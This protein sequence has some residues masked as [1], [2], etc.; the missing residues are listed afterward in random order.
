M[1]SY[2]LEDDLTLVNFEGTLTET[3]L[4]RCELVLEG[5]VGHLLSYFGSQ[6]LNL[7]R[8]FVTHGLLNAELVEELVQAAKSYDDKVE[9]IRTR[10]REKD[11]AND[12]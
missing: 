7:G 3:N 4:D 2:F 10:I 5:D 12:E 1:R 11:L 9:Q 6:R 8:Y